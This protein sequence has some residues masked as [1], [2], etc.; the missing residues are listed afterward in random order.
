M[1]IQSIN[2]VSLDN[3]DVSE[4]ARI[5]QG[6][7]EIEVQ[8]MV[9]TSRRDVEKAER[10]RRQ[11]GNQYVESPVEQREQFTLA[12]KQ[13]AVRMASTPKSTRSGDFGGR[14]MG[15]QSSNDAA[16][17]DVFEQNHKK[18]TDLR[19]VTNNCITGVRQRGETFDEFL[20]EK[21]VKYDMLI[22]GASLGL[23]LTLVDFAVS[24]NTLL[25]ACK[26]IHLIHARTHAHTHTHTH[27]HTHVRACTRTHLH[28]HEH[29]CTCAHTQ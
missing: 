18:P 1:H 16:V 19:C 9:R 26:L 23:S 8:L 7:G 14:F 4:A 15:S 12:T 10:L 3:R 21:E 11:H 2:G 22:G 29:S 17:E 6:A 5:M 27:T 20:W 24:N 13:P 28:M 25:T